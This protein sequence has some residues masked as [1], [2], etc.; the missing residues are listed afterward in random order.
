MPTLQPFYF[1]LDN[2]GL[3]LSNKIISEEHILESGEIKIILPRFGLYFTSTLSVYGIDSFNNATLLTRNINYQCV[4]L[5]EKQTIKYGKEICG[6]IL[7]TNTITNIFRIDYQALGGTDTVNVKSLLQTIND[8]NIDNISIPWEDVKNK[9]KVFTPGKHLHDSKD[10]YGVEYLSNELIRIG[11]SI[12]IPNTATHE[13]LIASIQRLVLDTK[14]KFDYFY[15]DTNIDNITLLL[16]NLSDKLDK[17]KKRIRQIQLKFLDAESLYNYAE[18]ILKTKLISFILK[19]RNTNVD[20]CQDIIFTITTTNVPDGTIIYYRS[21]NVLTYKLNADVS[22]LS[23]GLGITYTVT[24][25]N[26]PDGTIIYYRS[27]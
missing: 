11:N 7:L 12:N 23:E 20:Y 18:R 6:V 24:T 27:I 16:D 26:V 9:P 21:L 22:S 8:L 15:Q 17:L 3:A 4:E 14:T 5:S 10:L 13:H 19:A 2:T 1:E 25:T